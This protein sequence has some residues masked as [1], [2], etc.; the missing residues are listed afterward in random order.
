ME[1]N[2]MVAYFAKGL[3]KNHQ[4]VTL[5]GETVMV[6]GWLGWLG[7][8]V[9]FVASIFLKREAVHFRIIRYSWQTVGGPEGLRL[10]GGTMGV[11]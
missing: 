9:D 2:L 8:F 7:E 6:L 10:S 1:S 4:L 11:I 5:R 3:V